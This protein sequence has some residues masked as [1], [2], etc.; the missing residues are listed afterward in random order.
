M[1]KIDIAELKSLLTYD[2]ET[3]YFTW[4]VD[5]PHT[6][7]AGDRA[8]CLGPQGY[9]TI[10]IRRQWHRAHRLAWLYMTG[11]EPPPMLDHADGNRANNCWT[12]LREATVTQNNANRRMETTNTSGF[13]GVYFSKHA[14]RWRAQISVN[15][16]AKNLG[17]F[18]TPELAHE[19]YLAAAR[20]L[21]GEFARAA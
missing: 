10:N 2:P 3:G 18:D 19:A 15:N 20:E 9:V 21:F 4:L 11:K 7:K 17:Y 14:K 13:K 8:G 1:P 16:K 12:N 6:V 5:R